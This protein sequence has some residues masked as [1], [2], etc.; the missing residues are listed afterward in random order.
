MKKVRLQSRFQDADKNYR[1]YQ[2]TFSWSKHVR[3]ICVNK[4]GYK[5]LVCCETFELYW[6]WHN[7]LF[8]DEC[9][10]KN[11]DTFIFSPNLRTFEDVA[12]S[13]DRQIIFEL[14]DLMFSANHLAFCVLRQP[15]NQQ[16]LIRKYLKTD[17]GKVF[18]V[19]FITDSRS[20][21]FECALGANVL[22]FFDCGD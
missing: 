14:W 5:F 19:L 4:L 17:F 15:A 22:N 7:S 20:F 10:K 3:I 11:F 13:W 8:I 16:S 2:I 21:M 6:N 1:E 9:V 12:S 18:C